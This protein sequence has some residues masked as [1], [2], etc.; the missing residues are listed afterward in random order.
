[1]KRGGV[2]GTSA[3]EARDG[4]GAEAGTGRA[5]GAGEES[6]REAG[7]RPNGRAVDNFRQWKA[8]HPLHLAMRSKNDQIDG[9]A[10]TNNGNYC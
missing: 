5:K 7:G 10:M 6:G 2:G 1:M 8:S 4:R 3:T 9:N